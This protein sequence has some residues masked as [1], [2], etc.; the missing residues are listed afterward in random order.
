MAA[1]AKRVIPFTVSAAV[2]RKAYEQIA[3]YP[4]TEDA[5]SGILWT[6]TSYEKLHAA[7]ALLIED[8]FHRDVPWSE[9][10]MGHLKNYFELMFAVVT[11][12]KKCCVPEI[13][14]APRRAEFEMFHRDK[15]SSTVFNRYDRDVSKTPLDD[16]MRKWIRTLGQVNYLSGATKTDLD[17]FEARLCHSYILDYAAID[18]MIGRVSAQDAP[19]HNT[20]IRFLAATRN[21]QITAFDSLLTFFNIC[22][23]DNTLSEFWSLEPKDGEMR[24][25]Q[26]IPANSGQPYKAVDLVEQMRSV[27]LDVELQIRLIEHPAVFKEWWEHYMDSQA[28]NSMVREVTPNLAAVTSIVTSE[29]CE[30]RVDASSDAWADNVSSYSQMLGSAFDEMGIVSASRMKATTRALMPE[31]SQSAMPYEPSVFISPEELGD[32]STSKD[33]YYRITSYLMSD[34]QEYGIPL[35]TSAAAVQDMN[36]FANDFTHALKVAVDQFYVRKFLIMRDNAALVSRATL[37]CTKAGVGIVPLEWTESNAAAFRSKEYPKWLMD[38]RN[39]IIV[40]AVESKEFN[41]LLTFTIADAKL[42]KMVVSSTGFQPLHLTHGPAAAKDIFASVLKDS[43]AVASN[44]QNACLAKLAKYAD[45]WVEKVE[46]PVSSDTLRPE[47]APETL[48]KMPDLA[49]IVPKPIRVESSNLAATAESFQSRQGFFSPFRFSFDYERVSFFRPMDPLPRGEADAFELVPKQELQAK[50]ADANALLLE[51][52]KTFPDWPTSPDN[53]AYEFVKNLFDGVLTSSDMN[54]V[55]QYTGPN[56]DN[57]SVLVAEAAGKRITF[58]KAELFSSDPLKSASNFDGSSTLV[59]KSARLAEQAIYTI[60]KS[61]AVTAFFLYRLVQVLTLENLYDDLERTFQTTR[62]QYEIAG[63]AAEKWSASRAILEQTI[64]RR[65]CNGTMDPLLV[66]MAWRYRLSILR[67]GL[68]NESYLKGLGN[69]FLNIYDG[70][71]GYN[72]HYDDPIIN[73]TNGALLDL[74]TIAARGNAMTAPLQQGIITG[75]DHMLKSIG[76]KFEEKLR[77]IQLKKEGAELGVTR[78]AFALKQA[79]IDNVIRLPKTDNII[80]I[81]T[82]LENAPFYGTKVSAVIESQ[83]SNTVTVYISCINSK[84]GAK[85]YEPL[86]SYTFA[87]TDEWRTT[88]LPQY[89]EGKTFALPGVITNSNGFTVSNFTGTFGKAPIVDN[90]IDPVPYDKVPKNLQDAKYTSYTD[91]LVP[92]VATL[93]NYMSWASVQLCKTWTARS[94]AKSQAY[95]QNYPTLW[96]SKYINSSGVLLFRTF[97]PYA[98]K[99]VDSQISSRFDDAVAAVES[100]VVSFTKSTMLNTFTQALVPPNAATESN[101]YISSVDYAFGYVDEALGLNIYAGNTTAREYGNQY[102]IVFCVMASITAALAAASSVAS[103]LNTSAETRKKT[104]GNGLMR[105]ALRLANILTMWVYMFA[106]SQYIR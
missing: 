88:V 6:V 47:T 26:M 24:I 19:D 32:I 95:D 76:S 10:A 97:S 70:M 2:G 30:N 46:E 86:P 101:S 49:R 39:Q 44:A 13:A 90:I 98:I 69:S 48:P 59:V 66:L 65:T 27:A 57:A 85:N 99:R 68:E 64:R 38:Y 84:S 1:A 60:T 58:R 9:K 51:E 40:P 41:A 4:L 52:F 43:A 21:L 35:K 61:N 50:I 55:K 62:Q 67:V 36:A 8:A 16:N 42:A 15:L 72:I 89:E 73:T 20:Q 22:E 106:F 11:V 87:M 63:R 104:F 103:Y 56:Q 74:V 81:G 17:E 7:L 14:M 3:Q 83:T 102:V 34:A 5:W 78:L 94:R 45:P 23:T 80:E 37:E 100:T 77:S 92:N 105:T 96:R 75:T 54:K 28:F 33:M 82:F 25:W 29:H 12:Y 53:A 18:T 93:I 31:L 91:R 79:V 71:L